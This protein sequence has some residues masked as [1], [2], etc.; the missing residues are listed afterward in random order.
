MA[1][2]TKAGARRSL[3]KWLLPCTPGYILL[4]SPLYGLAGYVSLTIPVSC[5]LLLCQK[6]S[7]VWPSQQQPDEHSPPVGV[8]P[9]PPSEAAIC[10]LELA[11]PEWCC[12]CWLCCRDFHPTA[13]LT[14]M[15]ANERAH[16]YIR[17]VFRNT[18]FRGFRAA[19]VP[20]GLFIED[21]LVFSFG[22]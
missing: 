22:I 14:H 4:P 16:F 11:C 3:P 8:V 13:L 19:K 18:D 1:S 20:G 15:P 21:S 5:C 12:T 17:S 7:N 2:G 6:G 10:H 9:A